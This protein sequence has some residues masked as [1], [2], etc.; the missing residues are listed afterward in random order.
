MEPDR[1]KSEQMAFFKDYYSHN[2]ISAGYFVSTLWAYQPRTIDE[3]ALERGDVLCVVR[4]CDDGWATS[5]M[6]QRRAESVTSRRLDFTP[7]FSEEIKYFLLYVYVCHNIGDLQ[8]K[9]MAQQR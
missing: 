5:F 8:L 3:F 2:Y 9:A 7:T 4:I 6:T 1:V